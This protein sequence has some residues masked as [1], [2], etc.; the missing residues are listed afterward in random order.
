MG[1]PTT[2]DPAQVA[3]DVRDGLVSVE[4]ARMLYKVAV[5]ADGVVDTAETATLRG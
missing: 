4:N 3:L 5:T 2:R 1:D